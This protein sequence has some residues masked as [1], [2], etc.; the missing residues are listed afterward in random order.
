ML[1]EG[2]VVRAGGTSDSTLLVINQVQPIYVS[3][4]VPQQQLPAIK[5]YMAEGKLQVDALPAGE[6]RP[7][8]G[9][10][11]FIDNAVDPTTGTIRLKATFGNE[12]RTL[13][14]G[15]FANVTLTLATEPDAIVVPSQAVQTGQQGPYVFVVKPDSTVETCAV[16]GRPHAGQRDASSPRASQAG[17]RSSTDGQARLTPGAKV[18]IKTGERGGKAAGEGGG[19]RT[20]KGRR[21]GRWRTAPGQGRPARAVGSGLRRRLA[22][23][24]AG[25]GRDEARRQRRW[26][27]TAKAPMSSGPVGNARQVR[28]GGHFPPTLTAFRGSRACPPP[29]YTSSTLTGLA[30]AGERGV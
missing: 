10:V 29:C 12:E 14:P 15:Q 2:N 22:S 5:R 30:R 19:R 25:G 16:V 8:R 3:F 13:W 1:N 23:S 7:V 26:G 24:G 6:P 18:E 4:T 27:A 9:V 28:P 21:R 17:E 20:W 11:T